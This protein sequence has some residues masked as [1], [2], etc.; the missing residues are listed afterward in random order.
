MDELGVNEGI[1]F[2]FVVFVMFWSVILIGCIGGFICFELFDDGVLGL[3]VE[4]GVFVNFVVLLFVVSL[5]FE[6]IIDLGFS[7]LLMSFLFGRLY[8][9]L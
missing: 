1:E 4:S 2:K 5:L 6:E 3:F 8:L 7:L 9:N